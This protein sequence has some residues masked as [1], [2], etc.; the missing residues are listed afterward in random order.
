M[1]AATTKYLRT[2]I[3]AVVPTTIAHTSVSQPLNATAPPTD[4]M[5]GDGQVRI[6][7]IF[8]H[9]IRMFVNIRVLKTLHFHAC[10]TILAR[11]WEGIL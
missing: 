1:I 3:A 7:G 4:D 9:S 11:A 6:D 8:R 10:D 2:R 5:T